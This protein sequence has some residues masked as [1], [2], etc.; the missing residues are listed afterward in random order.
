MILTQRQLDITEG[1]DIFRSSQEELQI[2]GAE[3]I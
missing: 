3:I 1:K 2:A